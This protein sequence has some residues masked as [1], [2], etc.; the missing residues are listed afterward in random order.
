VTALKLKP[1][2]PL[3][4]FEQQA[5]F[6]W[7][8][9]YRHGDL[10]VGDFAFAVPNGSYLSGDAAKRAIQGHALRSQGVRA[11]V[12]D[13]FLMIPRAPYHGLAIEFKRVGAAKPTEDQQIWHA[14]LRSQGYY[15][16]VAYGFEYAR[17]VT[18]EY[19]N[20]QG[21]TA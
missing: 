9:N 4:R 18:I 16:Q 7:I 12:P 5:Y 13:T 15:V 11:G 6:A 2:R 19:L 1:S 8:A 21:A 17:A 10:K 3:E 20:Q 14:R